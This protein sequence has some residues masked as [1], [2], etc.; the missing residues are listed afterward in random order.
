MLNALLA[1]QATWS[2]LNSNLWH[3][4]GENKTQQVDEVNVDF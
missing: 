3:A 4:A 1:K 2:R